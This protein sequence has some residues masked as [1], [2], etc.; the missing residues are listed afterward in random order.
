MKLKNW[1][2]NSLNVRLPTENPLYISH[3]DEILHSDTL[4]ED[5]EKNI[6]I[7]WVK[8]SVLLTSAFFIRR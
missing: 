5:D 1:S 7:T 2:L 6:S 4:T 8:P 3:K